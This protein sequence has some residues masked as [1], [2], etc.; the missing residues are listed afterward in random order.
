MEIRIGITAATSFAASK[1]NLVK[2]DL[3]TMLFFEKNSIIGGACIT[4]NSISLN[5]SPGLGISDI[6]GWHEIL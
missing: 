2:A 6:I 1:S 3:D 5:D 4:E